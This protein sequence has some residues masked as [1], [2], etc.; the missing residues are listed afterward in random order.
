MHGVPQ[1]VVSCVARMIVTLRPEVAADDA[2]VRR[3]ILDTIAIE[4]GA[5]LWPEPMRSQLLDLQCAGRRNRSAGFG[6]IIEAD[7]CDAGW[8]LLGPLGSEIFLME[9]MV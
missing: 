2:F 4:L 8:M 1:Y 9:I 6:K 5:A 7:G 3:L